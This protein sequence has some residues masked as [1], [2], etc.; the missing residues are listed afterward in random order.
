E[1]AKSS[2]GQSRGS[3]TELLPVPVAF[4]VMTAATCVPDTGVVL[5]AA[6]LI[7]PRLS[8]TGNSPNAG[9]GS[10]LT[11][12]KFVGEYLKTDWTVLTEEVAV[13]AITSTDPPR[14]RALAGFF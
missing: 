5:P 2:G 1:A 4:R 14:P 3:V 8:R 6:N 7:E 11:R 9:P 10:A 12:L 13:L